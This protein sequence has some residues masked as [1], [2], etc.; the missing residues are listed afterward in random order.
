MSIGREFREFLARGNVVDMAVG[1]AIGAAF[2]AIAR[3]LVDDIIMPPVGLILGGAEFHDLFLVLR[4]GDPVGPYATLTDATDA[5]AVTINYGLFINSIVTFL[6][7]AAAVFMLV[8]TIN[9]LRRK[10]EVEPAV[11]TDRECP[12]CF[13][14]VPKQAR[15][16]AHCT[17]ELQP[18]LA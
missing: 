8:R 11:P 7:V 17:S 15:R 4:G 18:E 3:S 13:F 5:G 1:I 6:I 2:G 10:Q 12:H 16:C 9:R 14:R